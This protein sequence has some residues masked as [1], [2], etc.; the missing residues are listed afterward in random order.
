ME[1][2]RESLVREFGRQYVRF[3]HSDLMG[4]VVGLLLSAERAMTETQIA[5]VLHVSKSP[6]NKMTS[7]LEE[8]KLVRR[9]RKPGDRKYYYEL[10][11]NAFLQ[12]GTN[13]YRL[14]GENLRIADVHLRS[15][16]DRFERTSGDEREACRLLCERLIEMREFHRRMIASYRR[17]IDEWREAREALPS[18]KDLAGEIEDA[19]PPLSPH[20]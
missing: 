7:R 11:P 9:V 1:E 18:V 8:L 15:A 16:L 2:L 17:F 5:D 13:L 20:I 3:G 4:R 10:A 19:A 14:Y 12:A 6:V